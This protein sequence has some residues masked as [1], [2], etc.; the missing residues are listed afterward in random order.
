MKRITLIV[1]TLL[2]L[3]SPGLAQKKLTT[4]TIDLNPTDPGQAVALNAQSTK[5]EYVFRERTTE[6][7][8]V[9]VHA[10]LEDGE[11]FDVL[12]DTTSGQVDVPVGQIS[13]LSRF[14][15]L[16]LLSRASFGSDR[17]GDLPVPLSEIKTVKL[18]HQNGSMANG[19]F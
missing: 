13:L 1:M 7:L 19:S 5:A 16:I 8:S 4:R 9:L 2:L 18:V 11:V 15:H 12:I 10:D 14:G 6:V 17:P 3:A